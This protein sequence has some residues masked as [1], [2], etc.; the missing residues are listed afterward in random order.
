MVRIQSFYRGYRARISL[1]K[2]VKADWVRVFDPS[3]RRYFWSHVRR[4]KES[5]W[6]LP[7]GIRSL[8]EAEDDEAVERIQSLVRGFLAKRR[9]RHIAA[10]LYSRFYDAGE[11]NF[12]WRNN[13][14][15][16]TSWEVSRWLVQL[17]IPLSPE[18]EV[19]YAVRQQVKSLQ[20]ALKKKEEEIEGMKHAP[21]GLLLVNREGNNDAARD[22][23]IAACRKVMRSK[24]MSN[25]TTDQLAAWLMDMKMNEY[26]PLLYK[27]KLVMLQI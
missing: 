15:G 10:V 1:S 13:R 21:G 6:K 20:E 22:L 5:Q 25:W 26:I 24:H 23:R 7:F 17:H 12:Y 19:L 18:D 9:T 27:N 2:L 4:C 8:F 14:T 11:D 16:E 3:S